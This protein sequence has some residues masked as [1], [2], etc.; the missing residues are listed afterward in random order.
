MK[1]TADYVSSD[2]S[3][4]E[5]EEVCVLKKTKRELVWEKFA[6]YSNDQDA[7]VVITS[8]DTWSVY[9]T[10]NCSD[11]KKVYYRC[12]KVKVRGTQCN[13]ILQVYYPNN[14]DEVVVY[15]TDSSHN[16][17]ELA[18]SKQGI[19]REA[20]VKIKELHKL[21]LKPNAIME[22]LK[23][24]NIIIQKRQLSNYLHQLKESEG[25]MTISLGELEEWCIKN[26]K[27]PDSNDEAFVCSH[28]VQY[29]D[30][31]D[32][33]EDT[34][35]NGCKFRFF[36]TTKRLLSIAIKSNKIHCDATYKLI[37]QG[38][39]V[40]IVG[41]TDLD[42]KFH[43]IGL[44][45][46]TE[47]KQND[48][49]FIFKAVHDGLFGLDNSNAYQP[50]VLIADG[51]DAIR[52]AFISIFG[53]NQM[54]M[55][56]A[57]VR[58]AVDKKLC[59]INDKNERHEVMSDIE[60]LQICNSTNSFQLASELFLKKHEKH[61]D[62]INYFKS[63]WLTAHSGWYEGYSEYTPSTNN[64]L[65]ATNNVIKQENTFRERLVRRA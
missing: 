53:S 55:C 27:I 24:N 63:E 29:E 49:E 52:N 61:E 43:P 30:D 1:R 64:A 17:D 25:K 6:V 8:E 11:G 60:Q 28:K 2:S 46:C 36:L 20:K 65:E 26:Q 45:V 56:W 35:E 34:E 58:R 50:E 19:S 15:K 38:F 5:S 54:V 4:S 59:L 31:K 22:V 32:D 44:A 7:K 23:Q 39:P 42:R 13:A 3:E 18:L 40:L 16:H 33:D 48:F 57:H 47:E 62:F 10:N 14:S 37:W 12:N 41:T 9:S 51:S 21:H